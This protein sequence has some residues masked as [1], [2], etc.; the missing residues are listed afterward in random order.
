MQSLMQGMQNT[1]PQCVV[2]IWVMGSK[3]QGEGEEGQ[4]SSGKD[5]VCRKSARRGHLVWV[6]G[7]RL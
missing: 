4:Q 7:S 6:V 3:L 2:L 5:M 1:W